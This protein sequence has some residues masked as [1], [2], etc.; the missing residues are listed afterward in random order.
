MPD[1]RQELEAGKKRRGNDAVQMHLDAQEQICLAVVRPTFPRDCFTLHTIATR[2]I[3]AVVV[4][5]H[6]AG[7]AE[8]H[9][10]AGRDEPQH[11][12]VALGKPD[13]IVYLA[14]CGEE[15]VVGSTPMRGHGEDYRGGRRRRTTPLRLAVV[16]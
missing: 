10:R 1:D 13:G 11:E 3:N 15:P 16:L 2:A 7:K 12:V 8:A 4:E 14:H 5:I 6:E 9:H